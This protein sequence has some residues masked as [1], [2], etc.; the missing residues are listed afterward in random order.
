M[1]RTLTPEEQKYNRDS[2]LCDEMW[3]FHPNIFNVLDANETADLFKLYPQDFTHI[4]DAFAYRKM[5]TAGDH[6]L[7]GRAQSAL[8]KVLAEVGLALDD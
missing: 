8:A 5:V 6:G 4:P 1:D 7:E 3:A 2:L